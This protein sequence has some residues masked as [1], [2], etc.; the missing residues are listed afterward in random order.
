MV[1]PLIQNH[2]SLT[3]GARQ[4]QYSV[5]NAV[6]GYEP[7]GVSPEVW[8]LLTWPRQNSSE[9]EHVTR[10]YDTLG[11]LWYFLICEIAS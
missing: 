3:F 1:R 6:T 11:T 10:S 5:P 2:E 9:N 4:Y 7:N 8:I